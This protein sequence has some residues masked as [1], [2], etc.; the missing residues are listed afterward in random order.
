MWYKEIAASAGLHT[1]TAVLAP[2][3][4]T[5][6]HCGYTVQDINCLRRSNA[7]V[8]GSNPA[9]GTDACA[10]SFCVCAVLCVG[11]GFATG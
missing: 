9:G 2:I 8:V 11:S 10:P 7:G 6:D 3:T 1:I 4:G 5:A